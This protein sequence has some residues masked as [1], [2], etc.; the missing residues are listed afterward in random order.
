MLLEF[1]VVVCKAGSCLF[2]PFG[3]CVSVEGRGGDGICIDGH[4]VVE[5][6]QIC[7]SDWMTQP[8][9]EL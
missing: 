6:M 3:W 8:V 7:H 2:H 9:R 1:F 4:R 5:I